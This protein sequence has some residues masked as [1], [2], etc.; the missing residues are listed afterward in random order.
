MK[1]GGR[2]TMVHGSRR[3]LPPYAWTL[4]A[5]VAALPTVALGLSC[6]RQLSDTC[7]ELGT[8]QAPPGADARAG[9][10]GAEPAC[11]PTKDP[12]DEPCVLDNALGVFVASAAGIEGDTDAGEAGAE[13]VNGDGSMARPYATI[14]QALANLG[15]KTRVYVCNGSYGEQV[16]LT[17][18]V[19]VYGGLACA[20]DAG[21]RVWSYAGE[22][23]QVTPPSPGYALT[24]EGVDAGSVTLEDLSFTAPSATTQG[25]SSI[26]ALVTSSVVTL[27]RV[28][29]SAG[30]GADGEAGADGTQTPNY[31]G[32]AAPDGGTQV[33]PGPPGSGTLRISGGGGGVTQCLV[34][35]ASAGGDGGLG[36][37]AG[38]GSPGLGAPGTATPEPPVTV[39]GRDGLPGGTLEDGGADA[40]AVADNDPG[41]D[42]L[43]GD[44]GVAPAAQDY[45][46]L[47]PS[48]WMP[49]SGGNG[50]PGNPGQGGAG[51]TDPLYGMC[52]TSTESIG[53]GGGGAGGCGGTGG[54]AGGGGGGSIALVS[55]ASTVALTSCTVVTAD[56]GNGGAGGAGQDGQAGGSGG[57]A[58]FPAASAAGAPGGNGAG[59]SGGAGGIG[60]ISAGIVESG[61]MI[62]VDP[63]TST[64][65]GSPGAGGAS[66]PAGRHGV[67]TL[68][69]GVDGNP[70]ASGSAG[71]AAAVLRLM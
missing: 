21:G 23:A 55:I 33:S 66:G 25:T 9:D 39:P 28:T 69:T 40:S 15:G 14:A 30:N 42:G 48:G 4:G 47:S 63:T 43:A 5:L 2:P 61:S 20:G 53:G 12:A 58:T 31:V 52:G 8:C 59:G 50:D 34:F 68:T 18:A 11:D 56:G 54:Q 45:G 24:V 46:T 19:S 62:T 49:S 67:G 65:P 36:C 10:V 7:D 6:A 1:I 17:T 32:G 57:N 70:G 37:D 51:A 44:G 41:A 16:R 3:R 13:S 38:P 26:A 22:S 35:G 29:L 64:K 60:G 27:R 71:T